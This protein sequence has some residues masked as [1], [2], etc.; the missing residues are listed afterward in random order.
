MR[1]PLSDGLKANISAFKVDSSEIEDDNNNKRQRHLRA[2]IHKKSKEGKFSRKVSRF[3]KGQDDL[4]PTIRSSLHFEN[5]DFQRTH[6]G[7]MLTL[8]GKLILI[9]IIYTGGKKM[10]YGEHPYIQSIE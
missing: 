6:V 5:D 10:I 2:T 9:I 7:G 3:V 8:L 4:A 1:K